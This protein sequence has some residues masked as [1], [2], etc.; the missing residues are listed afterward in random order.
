MPDLRLSALDLSPIASGSTATEALHRTVDLARHVEAL[1]YERY[2]LAEHH[3]AGSLAS[4]APEILI[5]QVAA[6][7]RTL[8]VGAGG[9]MLPNH[10]P[11]KVA[12]LFR[13]LHALFP[14]R[15]DLGLG[16]AAG[17]D[18]R[19]AVVLRG[20]RHALEVAD[21]PEQ[22]AEL[23]R[24]L[25]DDATPRGAFTT[26][27]RAIPLGVPPPVIWILGSTDYG[28][29]YAAEHGLG[30]AFAHHINPGD[31][32]HALRTYRD[33]FRPTTGLPEPQAILAVS[34]L[35][36]ETESAARDL[37][38]S[39]N[40][41]ILRFAGG[42][43][44]LPMPS[45]EEAYAH[46]WDDDER[47]LLEANRG[48]QFVGTPGHVRHRILGLAREAQV[49]EVMIMSNIHDHAARKRSYELLV[50]ALR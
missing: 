11:L 40:L 36:A 49:D 39:A 22:M 1:G 7:T 12:E 20:S 44:D 19:T 3:N 5:G 32:L 17:T 6:A 16:R 13:V 8:R 34:A 38:A 29:T 30:F 26:S 41:S 35:C 21:F 27:I 48:R 2:W 24:Y 31:A 47:S 25:S 10:S 37:E 42:L 18:P 50:D 14:G 4:S 9:I 23:V 43:R 28:A 33:Q 46:A 45:V 15:I